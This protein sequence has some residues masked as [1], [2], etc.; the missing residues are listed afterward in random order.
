[1][2]GTKRQADDE[3]NAKC[4]HAELP[5]RMACPVAKTGPHHAHG[6]DPTFQH[7]AKALGVL[8]AVV[9]I[10]GT[11]RLCTG[12]AALALQSCQQ[13]ASFGAQGRRQP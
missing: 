13:S 3:T 6:S 2:Y 5:M 7:I 1:M 4:M 12:V 8:C 9:T 10:G 11:E